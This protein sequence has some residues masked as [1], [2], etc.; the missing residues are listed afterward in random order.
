MKAD[1]A[2]A[3]VIGAGFVVYGLTF[4]ESVPLFVGFVL[5]VVGAVIDKDEKGSLK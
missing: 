2:I 3:Q 4:Q 5:V 1:G